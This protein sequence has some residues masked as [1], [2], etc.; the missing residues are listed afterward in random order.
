[1]SRNEKS[2]ELAQSPPDVRNA[3]YRS[4]PHDDL[5]DVSR[6]QISDSE[7]QRRRIQ[8][9]CLA[10][11]QSG[12]IARDHHR[13]FDPIP[14]PKRANITP[15]YNRQNCQDIENRSNSRPQNINSRSHFVNPQYFTQPPQFP[16]SYYPP[17]YQQITPQQTAHSRLRAI[18][19]NS[20]YVSDTSSGHVSS[21]RGRNTSENL[22]QL[23]DKPLIK[24]TIRGVIGMVKRKN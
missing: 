14:M 21:V 20:G 4:H 2:N 22:D 8:G 11:G 19:E 5:M 6:L 7:R 10:C 16:M 3:A 12:H 24:V 18:G 17:M 23:K 13:K 9:L 1:M 15:G